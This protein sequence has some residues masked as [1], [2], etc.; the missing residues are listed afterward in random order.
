MMEGQMDAGRRDGRVMDGQMGCVGAL[1]F[2]WS[3]RRPNERLCSKTVSRAPRVQSSIR[4]SQ[5]T[6]PLEIHEL[7][8]RH[9][10]DISTHREYSFHTTVY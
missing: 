6:R 3:Y 7:M 8:K 5:N 4:V 1:E 9:D 10:H 2:T